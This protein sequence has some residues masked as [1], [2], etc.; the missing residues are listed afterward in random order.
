MR[1]REKSVA[2][3]QMDEKAKSGEEKRVDEARPLDGC[4]SLIR[5]LFEEA[6]A[7]RWGLSVQQ[8]FERPGACHSK[9]HERAEL[10]AAQREE[11]LEH[12]APGRSGHWRRL[13]RQAVNPLGSFLLETY[14]PYLRSA[15]AAI[16]RAELRF[17][18]AR[19]LADSL[20]AELYGLADGKTGER[21]LFRYFHGTQFDE[22]VAARRY[23]RSGTLTPCEL[24]KDLHRWMSRMAKE[25]YTSRRTK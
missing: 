20:F 9:A 25:K 21:S 14:R 2:W 22:D 24:R 13:A 19:E 17:R 11:I 15:A 7:E 10:T 3:A 18:E 5:R 6:R 4:V 8:F 23:W 16:L 1:A 12:A